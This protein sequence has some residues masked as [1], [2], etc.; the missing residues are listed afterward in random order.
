M[1][2]LEGLQW[3]GCYLW[4][5]ARCRGSRA[6]ERNSSF[7]YSETAVPNKVA[8][9]GKLMSVYV[10]HA[11]MWQHVG[12]NVEKTITADRQVQFLYTETILSS[13]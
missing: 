8:D 7:V 12:S 4:T 11:V 5:V 13:R 3:D 10:N 9:T 2:L 6:M 1:Q